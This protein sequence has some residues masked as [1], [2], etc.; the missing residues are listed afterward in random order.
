[1]PEKS[2]SAPF[3]AACSRLAE[4]AVVYSSAFQQMEVQTALHTLCR[5][6]TIAYQPLSA[7]KTTGTPE[8]GPPSSSGLR[9]GLPGVA[10]RRRMRFEL[11][12]CN[13]T[14]KEIK[15]RRGRGG[16][17]GSREDINSCVVY[18]LMEAI[19]VCLGGLVE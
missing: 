6:W 9:S 18:G 4:L 16:G 15:T 17:V 12:D 14:Q 19:G 1:M 10:G 11:K 13:M 7:L 2:N 5:A 3:R 8:S